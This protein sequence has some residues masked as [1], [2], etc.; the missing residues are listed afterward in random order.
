MD[1]VYN[2][3]VLV[4]TKPFELNQQK[5]DKIDKQIIKSIKSN[6]NF[7][8]TFNNCL[9][10]MICLDEYDFK[11]NKDF[12][13]DKIANDLVY[14]HDL[15]QKYIKAF[16]GEK[17]NLFQ[18]MARVVKQKAKREDLDKIKK[19]YIEKREGQT[20]KNEEIEK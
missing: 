20:N 9:D 4:T 15:T 10:Y 19:L 11:Y 7:K 1:K 8:F 13:L 18:F 6:K 3:F 2:Q 14:F 17:E 12:Y 5:V 16:S